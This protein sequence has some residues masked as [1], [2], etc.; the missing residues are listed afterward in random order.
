VIG[1]NSRDTWFKADA[2]QARTLIGNAQPKLRD[3]VV[4]SG[5][6][7]VAQEGSIV[8]RMNAFP[9]SLCRNAAAKFP[10][11]HFATFEP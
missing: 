5:K 8:G 7:M 1:V 3:C 9:S 4:R 6:S 11:V 2:D 10:N